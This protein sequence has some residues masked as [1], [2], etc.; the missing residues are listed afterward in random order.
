DE[1]RTEIGKFYPPERDG[2]FRVGFIWSKTIPCQNPSCNAE[3][4]LMRQFWLANSDNKK[5][6]LYPFIAGKNVKF[7]IVGTGYEKLPGDFDP[8][9]GTVSKAVANCLV[10]RSIVD[11]HT[12]RSLFANEKSGE[13]LVAVVLHGE[14]SGKKYR[15][16][17]E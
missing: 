12:T 17:S 8:S 15:V 10:C 4:P 3:I 1:A 6:S 14:K 9:K 7:K 11:D 16:A 5:V 13:Q 2:S